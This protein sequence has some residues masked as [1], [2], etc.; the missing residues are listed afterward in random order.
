MVANKWD[1]ILMVDS[2]KVACGL[3]EDFRGDV[4]LMGYEE[5]NV[6]VLKMKA[7]VECDFFDYLEKT[8]VESEPSVM[9]S[10]VCACIRLIGGHI[11]HVCEK[12]QVSERNLIRFEKSIASGTCTK[13]ELTLAIS[14]NKTFLYMMYLW[15]KKCLESVLS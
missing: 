5:P 8:F 2:K 1:L 13:K 11:K 15:Q 9:F 3:K 7:E 12:Q 10:R 14:R 6:E 4:D